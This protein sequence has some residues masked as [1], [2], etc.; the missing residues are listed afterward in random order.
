MKHDTPE[1]DEDP[2]E[3][4]AH[5]LSHAAH[6]L[7]TQAPIRIFVHHNTLHAFQHLPFHEAVT[8]AARRF[9][10]QAYES[11]EAFGRHLTAGRIL[12]RDIDGVL[13]DEGVDDAELLVP[14]GPTRRELYA[15]RLRHP[16]EIAEG[17]ALKWLLDEGDTLRR[18]VPTISSSARER[19]MDG[20]T[21]PAR[22]LGAL[23]DA[24]RP[25]APSTLSE[26][27]G[28]RPRD[29]VLAALGVDVDE[30]IHPLLTRVCAA[31]VD[32][33]IAYWAM[34]ER[35]RGLYEAFRDL[36]ARPAAP[37]DPWLGGLRG[38][39][40]RQ[41]AE[42]WDAE[43][44][45]LE[46]L[47]SWGIPAARWETVIEA[48]LLSLKGWAGMIH[49]L[50]LRP[51]Q[52]PVKAP[53]S[54]LVDYLAVF[55]LLEAQAV[56]H[57]LREEHGEHAG[58]DRLERELHRASSEP[59]LSA[60][61]EAFMS[62]QL[63]G[64]SPSS[65][66]RKGD[67]ANW[68]REVHA[69][70][71]L[72][73]RRLWHL[74]YE[75]RH[76]HI[77][78]DGMLAHE[79]MGLEPAPHGR[80]QAVFCIDEREESL[81]RHFEELMPE[82]ETFG[83]AG[84][85]NVPMAYQG[86]E[87]VK[88]TALCPVVI[89]PKHLVVEEPIGDGDAVAAR[90]RAVGTIRHAS[91]VGSRTFIRGGALS[92]T[93]GVAA[94]IPLVARTLFPRLAER[95]AHGVE[96]AVVGRPATRLKI[97]RAEDEGPV[98]PL[99]LLPGFTIDEMTGLVEGALRTMSLIEP[100]QLVLMVGHGSSSLNNPHEAAHDCGATGGGRGGPN[101]RAFAAMANHPEVRARLRDRGLAIPDTTWFVGAYHNTCDDAMSYY[102]VD[103]VPE[104]VK[105]VLEETVAVLDQA[106]RL[107]AHER[108]RR[109]EAASTSIGASRALAHVETRSV[110]LGEPRPEYGHATNAICIVGRRE[111]TRGLFL[112][113][114]AFLVSYDPNED[115]EKE[116]L[117]RLLLSVGPVG[118]GINLEYYFS[119]VDP[120]GY[121]CGTK[122]PHNIVG[123]VGVMDGHASD[124]RTG[125]PWQMVEIHEPVRLLTIVE[126]EP[127]ELEKIAA[128]HPA[129]AELVVNRW[130]QLVAWSPTTNEMHFFSQ[131]GFVPHVAETDRIRVT[132][133]SREHYAGRRGHLECA[134]I[135]S[136]LGPRRPV[137][138]GPAAEVRV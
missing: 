51:D 9:G 38:E 75:R 130:I 50:E 34:P 47:E 21:N 95:V 42:G 117:A 99:G 35:E 60:V 124:L 138:D 81:R 71:H 123:L 18:L 108:C 93:F 54:R 83:Y 1:P 41:A 37:P 90:R 68:L 64:V 32:Q 12:D 78:L 31:F 26:E 55:L 116:L 80:V 115:P 104:S 10:T 39:L 48:T 30:L 63:A 88:P 85:F 120:T 15:L 100:S 82:V 3:A 52:A 111:R 94:V 119:F 107:D 76:R 59:D 28:P 137:S 13:E 25:H 8:S 14:D 62:A 129:I 134:R 89:R 20:E 40:A 106:R 109:F 72:E 58:L 131:N 86:L 36:Y 110:D 11:E 23:W 7:P 105:P 16:F 96:H 44:V 126:A 73:R 5:A 127:H 61:Y 87:D 133:T 136:G 79:K 29:R 121:G 70:G 27:R 24:L 128:D 65:L 2:R 135:V 118:A 66:S 112:D 74:A 101:A 114:R 92:A 97:E 57:A 69:L 49:Q 53:P 4:L 33:G 17:P 122:L 98:E 84:F 102:D 91:H 45:V 46:T 56:R 132:Q 125:L 67:A 77:V 103:L 22:V 6:M 113:R 19:L 43:R